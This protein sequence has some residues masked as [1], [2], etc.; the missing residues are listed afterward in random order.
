MINFWMI[1]T[2]FKNHRPFL[3]LVRGL[4]PPDIIF[5]F[6]IKVLKFPLSSE[7]INH[8]IYQIQIHADPGYDEGFCW[9]QEEQLV[10]KMKK[11]TQ[12]VMTLGFDEVNFLHFYPLEFGH[13]TKHRHRTLFKRFLHSFAPCV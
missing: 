1:F 4:K 9:K 10:K 12:Q 2:H 6:G 11:Q 8:E 7:C 3:S 5:L 13:I